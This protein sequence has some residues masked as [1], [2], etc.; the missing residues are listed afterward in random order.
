MLAYGGD[1]QTFVAAL[2]AKWAAKDYQGLKEVIDARLAVKT[3]DLA[4]LVAKT[5]YY[6]S[7]ELNIA[8]AESLG[9]QIKQIRNSL[10][11]TN[12]LQ[13][14]RIL[15]AMLDSID[16]REEAEVAG[17]VFGLNSNQLEQAHSESPTNYPI[18]IFLPRL[19]NVQYGSE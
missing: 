17:Y 3:N 14:R 2:D 9:A 10:I 15:N 8:L 13:A 7:V 4:A 12:D 11:W 19:A 1:I 18:C 6:T 16:R 5:D